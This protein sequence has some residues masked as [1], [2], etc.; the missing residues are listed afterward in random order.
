MHYFELYIVI[1][2]VRIDMYVTFGAPEGVRLHACEHER[3][4]C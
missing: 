4:I 3:E 1:S 2:F